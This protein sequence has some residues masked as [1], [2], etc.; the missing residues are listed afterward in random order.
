MFKIASENN[1]ILLL[2]LLFWLFCTCSY[3]WNQGDPLNPS[4]YLNLPAYTAAIIPFTAF[5]A[6]LL[7][8][9]PDNLPLQDGTNIKTK[10]SYWSSGAGYSRNYGGIKTDVVLA[11][12]LLGYQFRGYVCGTI[13][14]HAIGMRNK[15]ITAY[16]LGGSIGTHWTFIRYKRLAFYYDFSL[17]ILFTNKKFPPHGTSINFLPWNGAGT[18][19]SL[20][21]GHEI[22]VGFDHIHISNANI[23]KG[24]RH[25][26]GFDSNGVIAGY[27]FYW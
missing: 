13:Q 9:N 21:K 27:V 18:K 15:E 20:R 23:I 25:N 10:R 11:N 4:S 7:L 16:G 2:V 26:P 24:A 1:K 8:T 19:I 12:Q 6:I 5:T 3:G 14:G 17:G 22:Q